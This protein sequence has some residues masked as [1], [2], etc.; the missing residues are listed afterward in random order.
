MKN[1]A[2]TNKRL[3]GAGLLAAFAA[4]LC[5]ITPVLAVVAGFSGAASALSWLAPF[6]PL[7]IVLTVVVLGFA[8]F[9][10][11]KTKKEI[12]CDCETDEKKSFLQT[13]K[14]LGGV[15]V[16]AALLLAFPYYSSVFYTTNAANVAIVNV[17]Q[18]DLRI[19]GMTCDGC[20]N[21]LNLALQKLDGVGAV[22]SDYKT[23]KAVVEY[24]PS[25]I[26]VDEIIDAVDAT[27][28]KVVDTEP[29]N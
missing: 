7:F 12:D 26:T 5:C 1:Q 10:Q 29:S 4:S 21:T 3:A 23:G 25:T 20:E 24:D 28:Y 11:L 16:L 8:W 14:F 22:E 15:T 27:G 17:Q 2:K 19:K 6:R 13:K 18:I 9:Q